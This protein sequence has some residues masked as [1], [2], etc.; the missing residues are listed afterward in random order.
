MSTEMRSLLAAVLCLLVIAGWSLIYKP[1]QPPPAPSLLLQPRILPLLRPP[2]ELLPLRLLPQES[3][4]GC[5]CRTCQAMRAASAENS[6]VIESDLYRVEISNRGG[7]VRS[8]QLKK[9]TDDHKPPRTLDLVHPDAAQASG[10]WPFSLALDDPQ[11]EVA[12]NNALF[13]ITSAGKVTAAGAV[14][15]APAEV[16]LSW[17]DGHLEVTKQL[18]F[19]PPAT[20]S[21]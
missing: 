10:S 3:R 16:T 17:S 19:N 9:F 1:P 20:S 11:Q 8:W 4:E 21:T 13:E 12:A 2:R 7:V 18:K 5:G 6:V 14:L 15:H